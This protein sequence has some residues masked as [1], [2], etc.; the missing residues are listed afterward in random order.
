[1]NRANRQEAVRTHNGFVFS[2]AELAL[3]ARGQAMSSLARFEATPAHLQNRLQ[4]TPTSQEPSRASAT[5][6]YPES[7]T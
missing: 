3:S 1:M 4:N 6:A 2:D 7:I 5:Q